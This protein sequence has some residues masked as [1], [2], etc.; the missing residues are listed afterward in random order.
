MAA[1]KA[2]AEADE[3][4][5]WGRRWIN[6]RRSGRYVW[7]AGV[8]KQGKQVSEKEDV[9]S[10][11]NNFNFLPMQ[12]E[13]IPL[14]C[15]CRGDFNEILLESKKN[16]EAIRDGKL[17]QNFGEA[18]GVC[19][20]HDL[21]FMEPKFT[22]WSIRVRKGE[23]VLERLDL[24][25]AS[26]EWCNL[27]PNAQV[28]NLT[29][30]SFDHLA[31]LIRWVEECGAGYDHSVGGQILFRY[32]VAWK[33]N[34]NELKIVSQV[35]VQQASDETG[36]SITANLRKV[37]IS[38]AKWG[39]KKFRLIR[40]RIQRN[41]LHLESLHSLT[42]DDDAQSH[43]GFGQSPNSNQPKPRIQSGPAHE[44]QSRPNSRSQPS[45]AS[46]PF[47]FLRPDSDFV[48]DDW[49]PASNSDC[50]SPPGDDDQSS[51]VRS[52]TARPKQ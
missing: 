33:M 1:A 35:W 26:T 42:P 5:G 3:N 19:G 10:G 24:V 48:G 43:N 25:V 32:E 39:R 6:R 21:G 13:K 7:I 8:W 16:G 41:Q 51:P 36:G 38:L 14:P 49:K 45:N 20:L 4:W 40:G 15:L 44:N 28:K 30:S 18:L 50:S 11:K 34:L 37:G 22:C 47:V 52:K 9:V 27:F 29:M 17:I 23:W 12:E 46:C 31:V 2:E